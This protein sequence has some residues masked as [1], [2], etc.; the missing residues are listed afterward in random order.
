MQQGRER[1]LSHGLWTVLFIPVAAGTA[2]EPVRPVARPGTEI[3]TIEQARTYMVELINRDRTIKD[4]TPVQ[5]D[6]VATAAGQKHAE[7]MATHRYL[8]HWNLQGKLPDQR[9]TE[10][11]GTDY[12]RENI[13]LLTR[14][15]GGA[16]EQDAGEALPLVAAPT[17]T[18]REIEEIEASYYN[19][20]PPNDGH[21]RNIL[22]PQ[23]THVGIAL[24]RAGTRDVH[25]LANTQEFVDR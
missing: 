2:G 25:T 12:D 22:S 5:L 11:G 16:D 15:F 24:A 10:Q 17:F 1:W 18:R 6:P 9:Y 3:L 7:E 21:R 8:A 23:H 20:T 19:E 4:L 14:L 13:Y